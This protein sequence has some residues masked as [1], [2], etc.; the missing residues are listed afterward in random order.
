LPGETERITENFRV[1]SQSK[2]EQGTFQIEGYLLVERQ[3]MN[4]SAEAD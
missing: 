4:V 2:S 1:V 3:P